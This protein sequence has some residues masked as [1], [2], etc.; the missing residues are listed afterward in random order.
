MK[1]LE[2][3]REKSGHPGVLGKLSAELVK[4]TEQHQ[5][6][7]LSDEEYSFLVKE[8]VDVKNQQALAD[9]ET[10]YRWLVTATQTLLSVV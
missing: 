4:I 5:A 6:G 1:I 10:A 9:D 2:E 8:I 3:L 7:D